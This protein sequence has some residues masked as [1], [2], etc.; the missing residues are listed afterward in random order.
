MF[1]SLATAAAAA[2]TLGALPYI[3]I[4]NPELPSL[5]GI[6]RIP[7]QVFGIIVAAGVF[8]G[9]EICARY[10]RRRAVDEDDFRSLVGWVIISG[11]IG[12]HVFDVL[13]YQSDKIASDPLI[14]LK[15]WAGI[16]SYGGVLGAV[17]GYLIFL[18]RHP[19]RWPALWADICVSGFV[20]GFT[21]GRIGCTVV[22]DHVGRQTDFVLGMDY[23]ASFVNSHL[24]VNE[25]M[26]LH[27]LGL[28]ELLY[29]IPV[30]VLVLLLAFK[31]QKLPASFLTILTGAL[32]APVRF[33]LDFLRLDDSDP[34]YGGLTFAQWVSIGV[35]VA[36]IV[37]AFVVAR[38]GRVAPLAEELGGR[39]GGY[40]EGVT[41]PMVVVSDGKPASGKPKAARKA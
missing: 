40:R 7:I 23:P 5:P 35:F 1:A 25:A 32:Y 34:R 2:V 28:Y 24:H 29:L 13:A 39:Q 30:N 15:I 14:F 31:K 22:S 3:H 36:S 19:G 9:V 33:Y 17:V 11:F 18:K 26:R 10:A 37:A 38:K 8:I 4:P 6:G 16:S 20:T 12:A 21:I 27:N 41:A